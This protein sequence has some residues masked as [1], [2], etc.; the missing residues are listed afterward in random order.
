MISYSKA[1]ASNTD[2][3]TAQSF[4]FLKENLSLILIIGATGDD[5]FARVRQLAGE[6]EDN[7]FTAEEPIG[8]RL[9]NLKDFIK[10]SLKNS[11]DIEIILGSI[12]KSS[13]SDGSTVLYLLGE[14][15]GKVCLFRNSSTTALYQSSQ[16]G[17][18]VSGYLQGGDRL[19]FLNSHLS[20]KLQATEGALEGLLSIS[21]QDFEE[22]IV[23]GLAGDLRSAPVSSVLA[24]IEKEVSKEEG[25]VSPPPYIPRA[26]IE[27]PEIKERLKIDP[28]KLLSTFLHRLKS[29]VPKNRRGRGILALVILGVIGL[30]ILIS[31]RHK[32][33]AQK[34]VQFLSFYQNASNEFSTAKNLKDLDTNGAKD[35]LN[36]STQDLSAALKIKPNDSR[37]LSL[38]KDINSS[39]DDI[40]KIYTVSSWPVFLDLNLVKNNFYP[41]TLSLSTGKLL[42]LD[43]ALKSMSLIDLQTK[44]NQVLA[45]SEQLGQVEFASLNGDFAFAYSQDKG[46]TST[47]T[48]AQ[49]VGVA[50][51]PDPEWGKIQDLY[52]F[53]GNIYLLDTIKN[54]VWKYVA[55]TSGY[56]DKIP[57]LKSSA[58]LAGAKRILIDSS[59][60][61]LNGTDEIDRY[62]AGSPDNFSIGGLDKPI[63]KIES[64]FV[65]SDT[66]NLYILDSGEGRVV[67]VKKDGTYVGQI[68]GDKFRNA[69][70][71]VVDEK[72]KK[73]YLLEGT[74]IYAIDLH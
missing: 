52:G 59:V 34:E 55:T 29:A 45:G 3:E 74:N 32:A 68:L 11:E 20:E 49:K 50:I 8:E 19:L 46:V 17:Q 65:S 9:Q 63:K 47:D 73:L 71:L 31:V 36:K 27:N 64:F 23:T 16:S 43:P 48:Q 14:G 61:I 26:E 10:E 6:I 13:Q 72:N 35:A 12:K 5:I 33:D 44:N 67:I 30:G 40:L 1:V 69:R 37:A 58:N 51:G 21:L 42:L 22:E 2:L 38:Q 56:S 7:F 60:W 70:D 57:Y 4:V 28:R 62:T 54:Q 24:E 15:S 66:N 53:A 25:V 18:L 41:Q 39:K